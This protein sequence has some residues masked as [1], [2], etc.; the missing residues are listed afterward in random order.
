MKKYFVNFTIVLLIAAG[1]IG[2]IHFLIYRALPEAAQTP[3]IFEGEIFIFILTW[4]TL[5]L[6]GYLLEK[7]P[8]SVGYAFMGMSMVKM[9][10]SAIYLMPEILNKTDSTN[11]FIFQFFGVYFSFLAVEAVQTFQVLNKMS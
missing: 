7:K 11:S 9:I 10:V 8:K 3:Q 1:V 6:M 5:M 4:A 2:G